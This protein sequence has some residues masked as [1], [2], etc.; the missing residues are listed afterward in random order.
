MSRARM[1]FEDL[2]KGDAADRWARIERLVAE[3]EPE[4]LWL[5]FKEVRDPAAE[6]KEDYLKEKLAR[7]LSGFANTEG[8][9][10]VYG[11]FAKEGKKG[12]PDAAEKITPIAE[13]SRFRAAL[14]KLVKTL[15]DPVV[16]GIVVQEIVNPAK[17]EGVVVV[18]VP[19]SNGAPHRIVSTTPV[20][21]DKYM[22]RT[23]TSVVVMPHRLLADRFSRSAPPRLQLTARFRSL[24]P[25]VVEFRLENIGRGA[26]R[27]PAFEVIHPVSAFHEPAHTSSDGFAVR[28]QAKVGSDRLRSLIEARLDVIIY[29]QMEHVIYRWHT[30]LA[31][32]HLELPLEFRLYALDM[33]PISGSG[34]LYVGVGENH[35]IAL[36]R[37]LTI[38]TAD[39]SPGGD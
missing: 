27:R 7:A 14:E 19:E 30:R 18:F 9:I 5:D 10:L 33:Q 26:A 15:T 35:D 38:P 36:G 32:P 6:P 22:M 17:D 12:E 11:I 13:P 20:V 39:E 34:R 37:V 4:S 31:G 23:A 21:N 8:G 3:K 25:A 16:G 1:I 2:T 28:A 24:G 29:P